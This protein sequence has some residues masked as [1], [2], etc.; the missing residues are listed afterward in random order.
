M[1]AA[2][3]L[4]NANVTVNGTDLSSYVREARISYKAETPETTAMGSSTKTRLPGLKDWDVDVT[5]NN[6]FG[7]NLDAILFP[8]VG[9]AT[10]GVFPMTIKANNAA[11]APGNP[12]YNGNVLL[13]DYQI[14]GAKVGDVAVSPVK[15]SGSGTLSRTTS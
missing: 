14:M 9:N 13:A 2:I 15:F 12:C 8:L 4:T 1:P 11:N 3:V 7:A 6:D 10:L 5:F